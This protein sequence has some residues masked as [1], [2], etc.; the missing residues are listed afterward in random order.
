MHQWKVVSIYIEVDK[1][2]PIIFSREWNSFL[3]KGNRQ[4]YQS[5]YKNDKDP[6]KG[7]GLA[8]QF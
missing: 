8:T 2:I 3:E 4:C 5:F 7:V 1:K 6:R